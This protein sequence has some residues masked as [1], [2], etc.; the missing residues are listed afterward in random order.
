MRG[1]PGTGTAQV[2]TPW[3]TSGAGTGTAAVTAPAAAGAGTG[4][5]EVD[6]ALIT[7]ALLQ[8]RWGGARVTVD[9]ERMSQLVGQVSLEESLDNPVPLATFTLLTPRLARHHPDTL[10]WGQHDAEI[11]FRMG[12][13]GFV[14]EWDAFTGRTEP[15]GNSGAYC[16][17]G[18][19]R[20]VGIAAGWTGK[21]G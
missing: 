18:D 19:L 10:A 15:T 13:P 20:A 4:P 2:V 8:A 5:A 3:L 1:T 12:S 17:R 9:G 11:T 21:L 7:A 6:R 16:P 14:E